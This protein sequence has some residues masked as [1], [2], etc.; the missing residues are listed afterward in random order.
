M[1]KSDSVSVI[2]MSC[3]GN[4]GR[5]ANQIFQYA[6][7]RIYAREHQ[8]LAQTPP[9]I[10]QTL[11]GCTDPPITRELP[12]VIEP[13]SVLDRAVIPNTP[14]VLQDVDLQGFFQYH[15]RYYR[16]HKDFFCALFQPVPLIRRELD[17]L[18]AKLDQQG[19]TLV[20]LHLRRGDFG[21][22]T[23]WK[24]PT[25]WY[26]TWLESIW[27]TLKA[28]VL[29][30]ASDE[31]DAVK[32]DFARF[33]PR[34]LT[35]LCT[36]P[37]LLEKLGFYLD[38]WLLTQGDYL[39]IS[40]SSFSFAASMLNARSRL[41]VRPV[42]SAAGL[43]PYDPWDAEV[44]LRGTISPDAF[45][46]IT[47]QTGVGSAQIWSAIAKAGYLD[48]EGR[49]RLSYF[50]AESLALPPALMPYHDAIQTCLRAIVSRFEGE[51]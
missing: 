23:F 26:V 36:D 28:P 25:A 30:I 38:F 39:A 20:T 4:L 5:F 6:F 41:F 21:W 48:E 37:F 50:T 33:S 11:F 12:L 29:Y 3:L 45:S 44:R 2:S 47:E 22:G 10:G 9:W 24:A 14:Q 18:K 16:P 40:N 19:K 42:F 1:R 15:T 49:L 8:L 32:G 46:T 31:P 27:D 43:V 13:T 35:D 7:L 17:K 51:I 34:V